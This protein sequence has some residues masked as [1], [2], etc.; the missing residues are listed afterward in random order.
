MRRALLA[1]LL[2]GAVVGCRP[3]AADAPAPVAVPA[4]AT[5]IPARLRRLSNAEYER[6]ASEL[7]GEPVQVQRLLPP[8]VRQDGFTLNATQPVPAAH[9]TRLATLATEIAGASVE[10]NPTRLI[11]CAATASKTAPPSQACIDEFVRDVSH[12][13]FR[14]PPTAEELAGLR[15]LF[16]AGQKD[17]GGFE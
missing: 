13:A 17:A 4:D 12:R 9:A 6:A 8:D 2:V 1:A 14:R 7:L 3:R 10:R 15:A 11:P 5:L 16:D